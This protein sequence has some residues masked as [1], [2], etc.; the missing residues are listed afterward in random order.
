MQIP[1]VGQFG[2][3]IAPAQQSVGVPALSN[4]AGIQSLGQSLQGIAG[5]ES[6][7]NRNRLEADQRARAALTLA[8]TTND[9]HDAHDDVARGVM[10]GSIPTDQAGREFQSRVQKIKS[11]NL[12]GVLQEQRQVIDANLEGT[13][14]TLNRSLTGVVVKRQQNETAGTIDSFG[15]QVSREA[16]RQGPAWASEKYGAMVDFTGAAAGWTPEQMAA[17]KQAFRETATYNFFDAAG[18]DALTKGDIPGVTNVLQKVQGEDGDAIDPL[19]RTKLTHQ[20]Y[21]YQQH[22]IAA[23]AAAANAADNEQRI[24][25]NAAADLYNK[26]L[27]LFQQGKAFDA[28]FIKTITDASAGTPHQQDVVGL[29]GAQA[30]GTGFATKSAAQRATLLANLE[31]AET[32]PKVGTNPAQA[33]AIQVLR[34][35]DTKLN[36]AAEQNPWEAAAA[37]G[38]IPATPP[39]SATTGPAAVTI[40]Q[41]RMKVIGNVENWVG[42]KVS[43]LQPQEAEQ[44]GKLVRTLPPDQAATMLSQFGSILGDS[45]RTAAIAK[46]IGDKDGTLGL[47]MAYA[48]AQTTQGRTVAELILRG[49]RALK[50]KVVTVDGTKETGWQAAIAKQVNG[51]YSNQE[52]ESNAKKAAF[53]ILAARSADSTQGGVS[54]DNAVALATGGIV[55]RNGSKVPLPYGLKENDFDTRIRAITPANLAPQAPDGLVRVGPVSMPLEQFVKSLPD[56]QLVHAGQGRYNVRAGNTLVTNSAG[57][58]LLIGISP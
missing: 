55:D 20:L 9:L 31:Q 5:Q 42:H 29:L 33:K 11:T 25:D 26:G 45:E 7:D 24:R 50:D 51:A 19:K 46:Q 39:I 10:D 16:L 43:P 17:K 37:S 27:D 53:L 47:S 34:A 21:G 2:N 30:M 41:D 38:Q 8:T 52:V 48:N 28:D 6:L 13:T 23:Q 40:M 56:A 36:T 12:S 4:G 54:V 35:M 49:D 44:L 15:E 14:G 58:R 1:G 22:L 3:T 57:Q 32:D 18:T